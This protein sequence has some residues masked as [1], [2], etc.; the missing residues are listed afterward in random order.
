MTCQHEWTSEAHDGGPPSRYC[1]ACRRY[2]S[3]VELDELYELVAKQQAILTGVADA[4]HGPP[5]ELASHSH[6]DL[7]DVAKRV[8]KARDNTKADYDSL[9]YDAAAVIRALGSGDPDKL[10]AAAEAMRDNGRDGWWE[11]K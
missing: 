2:E 4:L 10:R 11:K 1:F 3:E 9:E 8:A 7:A 6:H 5:P